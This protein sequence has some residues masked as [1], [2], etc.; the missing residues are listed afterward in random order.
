MTQVISPQCHSAH[1]HSQDGNPALMWLMLSAPHSQAVQMA[2][3]NHLPFIPFPSFLTSLVWTCIQLGS[4]A[5]HDPLWTCLRHIHH[6]WWCPW[7]LRGRSSSIWTLRVTK[8]THTV[9]CNLFTRLQIYLH[10]S[11]YSGLTVQT[12]LGWQMRCCSPTLGGVSWTPYLCYS[13]AHPS[14]WISLFPLSPIIFTLSLTH[15]HLYHDTVGLDQQL[16]QNNKHTHWCHVV[17]I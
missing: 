9:T 2:D 8:T 4:G 12:H 7:R 16:L 11:T 14:T 13:R 6:S 15:T 10:T 3:S 17:E 1:A 5:S